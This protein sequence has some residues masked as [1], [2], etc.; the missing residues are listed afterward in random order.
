M[1]VHFFASKIKYYFF[2]I[3]T[4]EIEKITDVGIFVAFKIFKWQAGAYIVNL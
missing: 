4:I 3:P 2:I 1:K